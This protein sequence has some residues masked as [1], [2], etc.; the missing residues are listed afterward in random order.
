MTDTVVKYADLAVSNLTAGGGKLQDDQADTFYR[1]V[2]DRTGLIGDVRTV[3][4]NSDTMNINK[5]GLANRILRVAPT[6]TPPYITDG[7]GETFANNRNLAAADRFNPQFEQV[8]LTVK[9]Y[10]AEIHLTDDVIENNLEKDNLENVILDMA[11]ARLALDLEEALIVGDTADTA[12]APELRLQD[13]VLKRVTSN[14]VDHAAAAQ[15][16]TLY[17]NIQ[18]ALPTRYLRNL[19]NMKYYVHNHTELEWREYL[20]TRETG[21]GDQ[22]HVSNRQVAA[23][24]TTF[25]TVPNMPKQTV[26]FTDPKNI[27]VGLQ[28]NMRLEYERFP[29]SRM[30]AFI[31]TFKAGFQLEEE[32][33]M[34]KAI[35]VGA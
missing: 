30:N 28:R 6:G 19:S 27:L 21:L 11:A 24:G 26:L 14:V 25:A 13:G 20:A 1:K 32:E 31:F 22:T 5:I 12:L 8:V 23:L 15:D 3:Q 35:N 18:K 17:A 33:A 7:V 16:L 4:M 29:R 9:E 34:V 2:F 10:M